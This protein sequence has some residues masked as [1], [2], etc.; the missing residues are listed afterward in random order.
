MSQKRILHLDESI[1]AL[2]MVETKHTISEDWLV[3]GIFEYDIKTFS[4]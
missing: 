4:C 2:F 3:E 1:K